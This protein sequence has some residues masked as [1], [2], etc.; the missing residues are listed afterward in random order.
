MP[1][2][3]VLVPNKEMLAP[4]T[5]ALNEQLSDLSLQAKAY[6]E[7]EAIGRDKDI[8]VFPIEHI[9]G[10]EF[11]AVFFL[12]VDRLA[13]D[14]PELFDRYIYVGATRA[15]TFLGITASGPSLP[16]RLEHPDQIYGARW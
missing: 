16:S 4:L 7:G 6:S 1:T 12:D 2:I 3:A 9:K 10:L 15:A 14:E 13:Q 8:R 11:E 5:A